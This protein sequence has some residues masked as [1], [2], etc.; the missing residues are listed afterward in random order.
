MIN[1]SQT[2]YIHSA[3]KPGQLY[4]HQ[5]DEY[6][7]VGRSNVGKSSLIN[8]LTTRKKLA[9]ISKKPGKTK[10]INYFLT[11]NKIMLVDLPGYGFAH[12]DNQTKDQWGKT[13]ESYLTKSNNLV[14]IFILWDFRIAPN[15]WDQ[16]FLEWIL[17]KK[18][19]FQIILTK[20]DKL[21]Y[22]QQKKRT[23]EII[24]KLL[25]PFP[26]LPFS[27]STKKGLEDLKNLITIKWKE[28][29]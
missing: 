27:S 15:H 21:S 25:Y 5:F 2:E 12:V 4:T 7:F 11:D 8:C 22:T 10:T 17:S 20:S 3:Y 14:M 13:I 24:S 29:N 6:A 19:P 23:E 28:F 9:H 26:L 18:L 1:F 16:Q